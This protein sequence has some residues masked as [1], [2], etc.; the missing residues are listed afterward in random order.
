M[1]YIVAQQPTTGNVKDNVDKFFVC[2][3]RSSG[4]SVLDIII[5]SDSIFQIQS[6]TMQIEQTD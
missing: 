2:K 6:I 3:S 1:E 5:H 4:I